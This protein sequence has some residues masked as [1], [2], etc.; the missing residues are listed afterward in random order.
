MTHNPPGGVLH[1]VAAE[2]ARH[3]EWQQPAI[4]PHH[5]AWQRYLRAIARGC[6][7]KNIRKNISPK[8]NFEVWK[9]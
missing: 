5:L 7:D 2:L 3:D 4:L 9:L 1:Q 8:L 6:I